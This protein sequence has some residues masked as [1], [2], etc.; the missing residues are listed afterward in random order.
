[1]PAPEPEPEALAR[2]Y[3]AADGHGYRWDTAGC[4]GCG[5]ETEDP[6]PLGASYDH[7]TDLIARAAYVE[8]YL[9]GLRAERHR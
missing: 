1:M 6:D 5:L 4:V 9:A 3:A 7:L 2:A 8:G